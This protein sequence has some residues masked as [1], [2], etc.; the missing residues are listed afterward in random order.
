MP[1]TLLPWGGGCSGQ[2]RTAGHRSLLVQGSLALPPP[3]SMWPHPK[4]ALGTQISLPD[5]CAFGLAAHL[6]F[7][8][9]GRCAS[10][11]GARPEQAVC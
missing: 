8:F 1:V 2:A 10:P 5:R 9:A 7:R 6:H 4:A 3:R 11:A